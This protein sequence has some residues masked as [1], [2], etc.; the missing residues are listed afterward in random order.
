MAHIFQYL[1]AIQEI[2]KEVGLLVFFDGL[3]W[4]P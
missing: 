3:H 4:S 1:I 2:D